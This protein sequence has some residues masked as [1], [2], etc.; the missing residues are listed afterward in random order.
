MPRVRVGSDGGQLQPF[1][2]FSAVGGSVGDTVEARGAGQEEA[3]GGGGVQ[4]W[5]KG[6]GR[7]DQPKQEDE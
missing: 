5:A 4:E 6:G 2:V 1:L 7:E 3:V